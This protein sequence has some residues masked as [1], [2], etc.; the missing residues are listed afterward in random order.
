MTHHVL[1]EKLD[2]GVHMTVLLIMRVYFKYVKVADGMQYVT[3]TIIVTLL[4]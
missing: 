2:Y 4:K 1:M 3:T